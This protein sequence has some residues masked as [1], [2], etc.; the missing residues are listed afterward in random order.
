[1]AVDVQSLAAAANDAA[2]RGDFARAQTLWAD[3]HRLDPRHPEGLRGLAIVAR[4][5]GDLMGAAD[6]LVAAH[7]AAPQDATIPLM[8]AEVHRDANSL[9]GEAE[10]VAVALAIDPYCWP[11]LLMR[12]EA[13]R[14]AGRRSLAVAD[15]RNTLTVAPPAPRWPPLYASRLAAAARDVAE[16]SQAFE[17]HLVQALGASGVQGRWREAAAIMAGRTRP[18][19]ADCNQLTV[20]RLPA[21]PFFER[22]Q[23]PWVES[24][25]ART[26]AIRAELLAALEGQKAEFEPYIAY[27]PGEP[28]NQWKDLNHSLRW[29]T[30]HLYRSGTPVSEHL[31]RCPVTASALSEVDMADIGGLCPNAMFSSLA[32]HTEIPPHHGET[33]ARLVVHLPLIVPDKCLYRVG[34]EER[35]WDVGKVLIFDDTLEHTARNDSD[36]LRVVLIFDVWNPLLSTDER[37]HVRALTNAARSFR[38]Q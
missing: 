33:N 37:D 6:Y 3:L 11:A 15:F 36:E 30:Y 17:A 32:P 31:A 12:G 34:F 14:R 22:D 5:R 16:F 4:Q 38:F 9:E 27:K 13:H 7:Q 18:Y 29:S 24:L 26:D 2:L 28:V 21:I 8:L 1:M 20:P 23:F 25:E 10:S 35:R 19:H